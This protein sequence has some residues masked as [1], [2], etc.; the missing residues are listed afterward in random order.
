MSEYRYKPLYPEKLNTISLKDRESKVRVE[1]FGKAWKEGYLFREWIESLPNILA[2]KDLKEL[3]RSVLKAV[4]GKRAV[5]LAMGAHVIKVGLSPLIIDLMERGILTS[6]SVNGACLVHDL[7]IA[8]EGKTSEEVEKHLKDGS[9]GVS[10]ETGEIINRAFNL[11]L[12]EDVGVGEAMGRVLKEIPLK[13]PEY[14]IF[15]KAW[16][17]KVPVTVH[18]AI[19]TDIIHF[20]PGFSGE[21]MGK[22]SL[23]DF[24]LFS[25]IIRELND[26]GVFLNFGSAVIIPE[27]FLKAM[28]YVR[29]LGFEVKNFTTA[30][31][32]FIVQYRAL[33]NIAERPV[34]VSGKGY[35]FV[36]HHEILIP[37]FT[38]M[39]KELKS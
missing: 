18:I 29:N 11:C 23:R 27:V 13:Y 39:L 22:G 7:E 28:T 31:F 36:G 34:S 20:H 25:S 21:G 4:K 15:L 8:L 17:L 24:F 33:K 32:D 6:I 30:V 35:Y 14:S 16:G 10:K 37:L 12:N 38:G 5:M 3:A 26:G 19:G 9:F 2:G 1:D